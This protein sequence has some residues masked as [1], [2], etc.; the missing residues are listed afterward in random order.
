MRRD[1]R[2]ELRDA[3]READRAEQLEASGAIAGQQIDQ[4][5]AG[6]QLAEAQSAST[7]ASLAV[8]K[9][10]IEKS[11]LT[12]PFDGTVTGVFLEEGEFFTAMS[13]MGGPPALVSV[14]ALDVIRVDVDLPDVDLARVRAG[15]RALVSSDALPDSSWEGEVVVVGASANAGSR[16]FTVRVRVPNPDGTLRPGLFLRVKLVLEEEAAV[17][18]VPQAAVAEPDGEPFVMTIDGTT[19]R[20]RPV[21]IGL[22][23]D[24]GWAVAG[25][26]P[27]ERVVVEGQFG[28]PDGA[29]V[30]V[31]D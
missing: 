22:K 15:M 21:T 30:R 17:I 5:R 27:G 13:G 24:S 10:Q 3:R 18:A 16:T 29:T 20:R 2:A 12:A 31:I 28:L 26:Q 14:D 19:A 25:L 8:L 23:G 7:E 9:D 1:G 4:A 6:L 11:T